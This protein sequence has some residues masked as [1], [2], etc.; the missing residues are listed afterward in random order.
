MGKDANSTGTA[1]KLLFAIL[2]TGWCFAT[3]KAPLVWH[4]AFLAF[5]SVFWTYHERYDYMILILPL[6]T[7]MAVAKPDKSQGLIELGF[8]ALAL[9]LSDYAYLQD[10][11]PAHV[12]RWG[13]RLAEYSLLGYFAI[14]LLRECRHT[15]RVVTTDG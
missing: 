1:I 2:C 7:M 8:F 10:T 9:A 13:G 5:V 3:R 14:R 15:V 11:G 6:L 4:I 12:I